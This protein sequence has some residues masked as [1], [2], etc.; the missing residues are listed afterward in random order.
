MS[1]AFLQWHRAHSKNAQFTD[2][3]AKKVRP[4]CKACVYGE[5]RQTGT[6][7]HRV[8]RPQ[9]T[10]AGRQFDIDAFA[11]KHTSRRGFN[12]CDLMRDKA[13][14]MI[15]CNFT[16]SR[17]AS[18]VVDALTRTWNLNPDWTSVGTHQPD[19]D[20]LNPR[21]IKMDSESAYKSK[22]VLEF[23]ATRGYK[24]EFTPPRDKHANGTAERMVGLVTSKTN[25]AMIENNAPP[26]YWC[27]AMLKTS[28]DLNFNYSAKIGTS[29]YNFVAKS[30]IDMKYLHSFFAE[31][32]M[33]IPLS[34]RSS[35]LPA[36]RAQR[37]RFLAYSYTTILVPTYV[38]VPVLDNGTYGGVRVSKDIIFDESCIYDPLIDNSPSDKDFAAL[39]DI[40]WDI[41]PP[42]T[43]DPEPFSFIPAST[44]SASSSRPPPLRLHSPSEYH[45]IDPEQLQPA[46]EPFPLILSD[47]SEWVQQ[48]DEY[49]IPVYWSKLTQDF[50]TAPIIHIDKLNY[51]IMMGMSYMELPS[52]A[53]KSFR[54][55]FALPRWHP[56]IYKEMDNFV[57][58]TCFGWVRDIGQRRLFMKWIFSI[59]AD[60]TLKARLVARG[61]RCK[62]GI[63]YDPDEVYCGNVQAT[64]IKI[65]FALAALYGLIMRGGDLVG[66][67]LVTP[68]SKDFV[69]FIIYA[70][71]AP[72]ASSDKSS[73]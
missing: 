69:R 19:T 24:I 27:W 18:E 11:C 65:F 45:D 10:I 62:P 23:M 73:L 20:Q 72:I 31:C 9:P 29:P 49:G 21:I 57:D 38:V 40:I 16:K 42:R 48:I 34:E 56:A 70:R 44:P 60:L 66:A 39:P 8:H 64:S 14:Q 68:G 59:K 12:Y 15:Y 3:E 46:S 36:R 53:P 58:N 71:L 22:E 25:G 37:C 32:Y 26:S 47:T 63:D 67:Y 28:Q 55:A 2:A 30:H 41:T 17:S 35:K 50:S 13:S 61:D 6:D 33:F 4:I 54:E 43:L 5:S 1:P 51:H 7:P 52:A